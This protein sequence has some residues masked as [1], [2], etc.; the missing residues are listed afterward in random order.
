MD[1]WLAPQTVYDT[2]TAAPRWQKRRSV[3]KPELCGYEWSCGGAAEPGAALRHPLKFPTSPHTK[4]ARSVLLLRRSDMRIAV[5]KRQLILITHCSLA[6]PSDHSNFQVSGLATGCSQGDHMRHWSS[7]GD[8]NRSLRKRNRSLG[9]LTRKFRIL[10]N[11]RA[12]TR[13]GNLGFRG[14]TPEFP[15]QRPDFWRVTFGN[16]ATSVSARNPWRE[17][18]VAGWA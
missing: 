7:L 17:T 6:A 15:R 9:A 4:R 10:K 11:H 8:S 16:V 13:A 2:P 12:E 1:T 3:G 14:Q 5:K 18:P